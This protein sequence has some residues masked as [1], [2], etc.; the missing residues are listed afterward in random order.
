M[1][2]KN[3][4][5]LRINNV[6]EKVTLCGW[7]NKKRDLGGLIFIDLRDRWGITQITVNPNNPN[8]EKALN[9]KNEYVLKV[10]GTVLERENKNSTIPTGDIEVVAEELTI[11]STA[12]QPP[13]LIQDNTDALEDTRMKYR[14]LDLRRPHMQKNLIMRHKATIAIRNY[15]DSLD[16]IEVETPVFG[17]STPEGARDFLVPSRVHHGS[18]Y[19]L[20]QSPQLYKQLLMVAGFERYFQIV[21]CFRDEDLRADRQ[22]EFTQVDVEMSFVDEIDVQ[23]VTEGLLKKVWKDVLDMDIVTPFKRMTWD[24]AMNYYGSDKPDTRFEMLLQDLSSWASKTECGFFKAAIEKGGK[25]KAIVV[26]NAA[27]KYSRKEIDRLTLLAKKFH[28]SGLAWLK[29]EKGNFTG[30][31][32]KFLS[33]EN[34]EELVKTLSLTDDDLVLLVAD[35]LMNCNTALGA[36][37]LQVAKEL[38]LIDMDK[39][40]F[41]WV[42]DWP[43]FEWSEEENRYVAAHHP[44][45][46]PKDGDED[47]LLT[48]PASCHAKAYDIV[49]NGYELGGGSI[50]IHDQ[51][52]QAK[53]FKAIGLDEEEINNKFGYFVNALR[54]GTPPHG[55]LAIGL[56]RL[57]MLITKNNNLREVIAFPKA[58]SAKCPMSGAPTEVTKEQLEELGIAVVDY[59]KEEN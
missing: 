22:L 48:D 29:L 17:K 26:K 5:E 8:Y 30:S 25:V 56:D 13:M 59:E 24:D 7:C 32:V 50:R 21:K 11:L 19:A 39:F 41:L 4:G 15:F 14:Y 49:L 45:T 52:I 12:E 43:L 37:R 47:R 10:E 34:K 20:P 55:G 44:F 35:E 38:N 40:N 23:N 1:R 57:A 16:F 18:F 54:Y 3:N 58:A 2:T 36:V 9:V 51:N 53:M 6:G 27:E 42:V 46:S 33:D 28:A 31:I